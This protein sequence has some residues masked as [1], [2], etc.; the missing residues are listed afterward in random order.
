MTTPVIEPSA[1]WE[2]VFVDAIQGTNT[3]EWRCTRCGDYIIS[4][5]RPLCENCDGQRGGP[6]IVPRA[7]HE[8]TNR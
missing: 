6:D 2:V 7:P 4:R 8:R 1:G 3:C 5:V